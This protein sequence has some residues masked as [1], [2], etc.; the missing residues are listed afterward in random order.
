MVYCGDLIPTRHH[1]PTPYIMS[2]DLDPLLAMDEKVKL[3]EQACEGDWALF[4]E[5][6]A[7]VAS[8]LVKNDRGKFSAGETVLL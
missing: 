2:Y 4:F 1:I 3:L 8:C 5:H 6:D 7:H